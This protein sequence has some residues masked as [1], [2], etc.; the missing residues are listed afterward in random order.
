ME[1]DKGLKVGSEEDMLAHATESKA[2]TLKG[3]EKDVN[4]K[5]A[6]MEKYIKYL[7]TRINIINKSLK[8]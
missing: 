2:L 1:Y 7:E 3:L 6:E 8:R 4:L 5:F